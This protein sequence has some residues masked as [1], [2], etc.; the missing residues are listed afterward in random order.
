MLRRTVAA[1]AA[2]GVLLSFSSSPAAFADEMTFARGDVDD[3][4]A[5]ALQDALAI[6]NYLFTGGS[7]P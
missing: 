6:L 1:L 7:L 3:D 2:L 5:V 4:A